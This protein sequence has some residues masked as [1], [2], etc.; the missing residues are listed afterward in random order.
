MIINIPLLNKEEMELLKVE[1]EARLDILFRFTRLN[2]T[3]SRKLN[4]T[5]F[6]GSTLV[7]C[8]VKN[9]TN[10]NLI[11]YN[12]L[13]RKR[14]ELKFDSFNNKIGVKLIADT[15]ST[16][17]LEALRIRMGNRIVSEI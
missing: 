17:I 16:A 2:P 14:F 6:I 1:L 8:P 5:S 9:N 15:Y 3:N 12:W 11:K 13:S 7:I 4:L 10:K